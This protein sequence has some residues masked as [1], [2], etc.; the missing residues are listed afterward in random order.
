MQA[1]GWLIVIGGVAAI[2]IVAYLLLTGGLPS[3]ISSGRAIRYFKEN[4]GMPFVLAFAAMII[5]SALTYYGMEWGLSN[6]FARYSFYAL[7]IGVAL[8]A[9]FPKKRNNNG[10]Q[11][12]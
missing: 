2:D 8:Q 7:L 9:I 4:P 12:Q 1:L 5:S 6:A 3:R 11:P 10:E